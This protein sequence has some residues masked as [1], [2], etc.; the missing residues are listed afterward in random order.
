[1]VPFCPCAVVLTSELRALLRRAQAA[2][3]VGTWEFHGSAPLHKAAFDGCAEACE[4][5]LAAGASVD[6]VDGDGSTALHAAAFMG[7]Y[8]CL[9]LLLAAGAAV[10]APDIISRTPLHYR[11]AYTHPKH[12]IC[13]GQ[14]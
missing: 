13:I 7:R 6:P 10:G 1:M 11:Q 9:T 4:A 8:D 3:T 12:N 2:V 5:L 14:P